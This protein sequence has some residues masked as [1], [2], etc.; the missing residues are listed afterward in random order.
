MIMKSAQFPAT[1]HITA[2]YHTPGTYLVGT[3]INAAERV[4][5]IDGL[6]LA[7]AF[8]ADID[9]A[10]NHYDVRGIYSNEMGKQLAIAWDSNVFCEMILGARASTTVTAGDGGTAIVDANMSSGTIATAADALAKG[11]YSAAQALDEKNVSAD[12]RFA[13]FR[14]AEYYKLVQ[15]VQSTGFA[16]INTLY[17]GKGSYADGEIIQIAGITIIKSNVLPISDLSAQ[18]YHAVNAATTKGVVWTKEAVGTVKLMDLSVQSQWEIERQGT[19]MVARYAMGMGYLRPECCC[20]LK[21][22]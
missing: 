8:I 19:L 11:L 18:T 9:E 10:M 14:P 17:G 12:G 2:A 6:L 16:A 7:Q 5:Q 3:V 15:G 21:T 22:S 4:I 13:A 1:G 20:E